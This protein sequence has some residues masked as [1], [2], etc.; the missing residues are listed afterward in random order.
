MDLVISRVLSMM[1]RPSPGTWLVTSVMR[2]TSLPVSSACVGGSTISRAK[3]PYGLVTSGR[4]AFSARRSGACS[5]IAA[6]GA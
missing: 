2:L 1:T 5:E 6:L 3:G 4:A